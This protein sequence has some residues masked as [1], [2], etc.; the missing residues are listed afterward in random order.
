VNTPVVSVVMVA[1]GGSWSCVP[2]ALDALRRNTA[3]PYEVILVDNGGADS[4]PVPVDTD[5]EIIRNEENIGFGP[6]SNQGVAR[7]RADVICLLNP[8]TFVEPDWLP[9]VLRRLSEDRV[10]A[11]FPAKLNLDGTLQEAGAVATGEGHAYVFGDGDDPGAPEHGFAR[12][13]DFGSA[14]CMAIQRDRFESVGG[15][16]PAYRIAYFEDVDLCF[17]LRE[18]GQRLVFEPGS[19]VQHARSVSADI[20]ALADIYSANRQVFLSR[21]ESAIEKRPTAEQLRADARLRVAARDLHAHDRVLLLDS[22]PTSVRR[23]SAEIASAH[24]SSRITLLTREID[25]TD[26]RSLLAAGVEAVS[27]VRED[28]WLAER[29]GHYTH[30]I[31]ERDARWAELRHVLQ[32]TQPQALFVDA[33]RLQQATRHEPLNLVTAKLGI[34]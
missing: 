29:S 15:F 18:E 20:G 10:G 4:R 3:D 33:T 21:W 28:A 25:K 9:S 19:R 1:F 32:A 11:V 7:A 6:G 23:L 2:Q 30:L 22:L 16:D 14:A 13:L 34:A 26:E 27:G 24:P 31:S 17:R 8:D 12:D 5:V